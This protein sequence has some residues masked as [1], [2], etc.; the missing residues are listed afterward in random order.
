MD[1]TKPWPVGHT[2]PKRDQV[3]PWHLL[4]L[5]EPA[6]T[7]NRQVHQPSVCHSVQWWCKWPGFPPC[8]AQL[9]GVG[10]AMCSSRGQHQGRDTR[11]CMLTTFSP[12]RRS[13]KGI[14]V[15]HLQSFTLRSTGIHFSIYLQE[16]TPSAAEFW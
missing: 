7:V 10:K 16:V 4:T 2:A 8:P 5:P 1:P 15:V 13:L 14:W 9:L 11:G 6:L 3:I 12:V